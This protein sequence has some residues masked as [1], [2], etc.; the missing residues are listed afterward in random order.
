MFFAQQFGGAVFVSVGG[1]VLGS[2]VV[3]GLQGIP[4]VDP[5]A[6]ASAGAT[7]LRG[8]VWGGRVGEGAAGVCIITR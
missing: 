2:E 7:E 4:G 8:A 6:V 1:N 3:R 5:R